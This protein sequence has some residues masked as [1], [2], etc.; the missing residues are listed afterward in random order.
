MD[1]S[2]P[3]AIGATGGSLGYSCTNT[4]MP[5]DGLRGWLIG[6]GIDEYGNFLNGK[7]LSQRLYRN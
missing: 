5:H 4:N 6:L 7:N 3:T 2:Q 1:G